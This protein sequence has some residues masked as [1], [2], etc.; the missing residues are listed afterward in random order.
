MYMWVRVAVTHW[1]WNLNL[2]TLYYSKTG[3]CRTSHEIQHTV[4]IG[5][6]QL[7]YIGVA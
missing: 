5:T 7:A 3:Y 6:I 2:F 1:L 4:F